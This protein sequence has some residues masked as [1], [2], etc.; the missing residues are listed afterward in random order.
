MSEVNLMSDGAVH[1][2]LPSLSRSLLCPGPMAPSSHF[3]LTLMR[4]VVGTG[5]RFSLYQL[6][7]PIPDAPPV[8]LLGLRLFL[9]AIPLR[10][11]LLEAEGGAQVLMALLSPS[12]AALGDLPRRPAVA[13]ALHRARL[14][15]LPR[16][17]AR[18]APPSEPTS[19]RELWK[20]LD[21]GVRARLPVLNDAVLREL[22]AVLGRQRERCRG[23]QPEP[24]F[25]PQLWKLR[26]GRRPQLGSL[27]PLDPLAPSWGEEPERLDVVLPM[28]SSGPFPRRATQ[29]G[30]FREVY[31]QFLTD[32]RPVLQRFGALAVEE[33][34]LSRPDDLFFMPFQ[35]AEDLA[36]DQRPTWVAG[37]VATNRAE[38]EAAL[39]SPELPPEIWKSPA[40]AEQSD[41]RDDWERSTLEPVEA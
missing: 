41:R 23:R 40:L 38:Y 21:S 10:E 22:L 8:R 17:P 29:R 39:E 15:W 26:T 36:R 18:V 31:R 6:G 14:R 28:L 5:L 32:L 13:V 1:S 34:V 33:G 35:L 19:R 30:R 7:L 20:A 4:H 25:A 37:A 12:A 11:L 3:G 2:S 24:A 27:G 16:P 9:D